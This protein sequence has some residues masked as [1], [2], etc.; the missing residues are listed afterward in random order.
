MIYRDVFC[1]CCKC[2]LFIRV[3][4]TKFRRKWHKFILTMGSNKEITVNIPETHWS[5]RLYYLQKFIFYLI[6]EDVGIQVCEFSSNIGIWYLMFNL[7]C[8]QNVVFYEDPS[9]LPNPS[10]LTFWPRKITLER[11]GKYWNKW[12]QPHPFYGENE[13]TFLFGKIL[14]TQTPPSPL[15]K[16]GM[17]FPTMIWPLNWK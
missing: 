7:R 2:K 11:I 1:F 6:R 4:V 9:I 17:G 12:Y 5:P 13:L 15:Y 8:W 16:G 10:F 14:K 3:K